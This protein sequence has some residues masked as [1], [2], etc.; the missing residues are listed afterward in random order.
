MYG[1]VLERKFNKCCNI[2]NS[3]KAKTKGSNIITHHLAKQLSQ[4]GIDVIPGWQLCRNCFQKA[5][6][7]EENYEPAEACDETD[8]EIT[9]FER[10][11]TKEAARDVMNTSFEELAVSP[12]RTHGLSKQRKINEAK[13]EIDRA[14]A[15]IEE[16]V[17]AAID[18]DSEA[19]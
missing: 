5:R 10:D 8:Y 13:G 15:S 12:T 9:E 6:N 17:A 16:R 4:K 18:V 11:V 2:F 3:H 1:N 19:N 14:C 7:E